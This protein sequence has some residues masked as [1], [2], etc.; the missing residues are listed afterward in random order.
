MVGTRKNGSPIS[1]TDQ[2]L[3]AMSDKLLACRVAALVKQTVSLRR[4]LTAGELS[5]N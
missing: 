2:A 1:A 3:R 4:V 5:A